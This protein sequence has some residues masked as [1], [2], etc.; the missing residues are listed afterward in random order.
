[1]SVS[2]VVAQLLLLPR[3]LIGVL[4]FQVRGHA[5]GQNIISAVLAVLM[6]TFGHR[7]DLAVDRSTSAKSMDSNYC[8]FRT[9]TGAEPVV[10]PRWQ[11]VA[12]GGGIISYQVNALR[13]LLRQSR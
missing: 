5:T 9:N 11:L 8:T 3:D 6:S 7:M 4:L 12:P 1:M 10:G 13:L 2:G